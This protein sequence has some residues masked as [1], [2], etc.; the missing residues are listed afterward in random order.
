MFGTWVGE[1]TKQDYY[2][3][4]KQY[5]TFDPTWANVEH[6]QRV[7]SSQGWAGLLGRRWKHKAVFDPVAL[8]APIRPKGGASVSELWKLPEPSKPKRVK[9]EGEP[10]SALLYVYTAALWLS[11]LLAF[12]SI[13]PLRYSSEQMGILSAVCLATLKCVG[14]L[15]DGYTKG[16]QLETGRQVL[17]VSLRFFVG[18]PFETPL[19]ALTM[20]FEGLLAGLAVLWPIVVLTHLGAPLPQGKTEAGKSE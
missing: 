5:E 16:W 15:C 1:D 12:V 11:T 6:M 9:Y 3:L 17:L 4:A 2:G 8:M 18:L 20:V 7:V 13:G 10:L 19:P 14:H